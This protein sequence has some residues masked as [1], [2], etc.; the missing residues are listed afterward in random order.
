M[1]T[2]LPV[3]SGKGGVGKSLIVSNL[4]VTLGRLGKT[5]VLVDLDLGG[6]NLHTFLGVTNRNPGIGNFI[7]KQS[8]SLESL[9]SPTDY[10]KVYFIAGDSMIPGTANLNYFMKRKI[11]R[12]LKDLVADY[13]II[14]LGAGSAY[15]TLDFFLVTS[16]GLLVTVPETTAVLN[17]YGFLKSALYRLLYRSFP[18]GST[19]RSIIY[20][21]ITSK[22]EGTD[23]SFAELIKLISQISEESGQFALTQLQ[24]IFPRVIL[25]MCRSPQ[26]KTLGSKLREIVGKNLALHLEYIGFIENEEVVRR[27]IFERKPSVIIH[28]QSYF[29]QKIDSIARRLVAEPEPKEIR[30]F[31]ADEDLEELAPEEEGYVPVIMDKLS[32]RLEPGP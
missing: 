17:T 27:S 15:N 9:I 18:K 29:S 5:V 23:R 13:I 16:K 26:D 10:D 4:G 1:T 8:P 14:D 28:P 32:E 30:L 2:I 6:S 3:A 24:S 31:E 21:F 22:I 12:Q 7:Y 11:I 19:E 25:N 20:N